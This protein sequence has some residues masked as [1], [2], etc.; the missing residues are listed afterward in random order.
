MWRYGAWVAVLLLSL[1]LVFFGGGWLGIYRSSLRLVSV[2]LAAGVLGAWALVAWRR[3]AWR[4]RSRLMPAIAGILGAFA[5]ST[6]VSRHPRQ[7]VEYLGYAVLLAALYLL[8]VRVLADQ[9][10]R[11]RVEI[12]SVGLA[13]VL[14]GAFAVANAARWVDWW[15]VVGRVTV[16][17]LRPDSEGLVYGNPS[18]AMTIV[19]LFA[20][21]ALPVLIGGPRGPRLIAALIGVLTVF[22]IVVSGSRA[23]WFAVGIA[24]VAVG[25]SF[26]AA[27]PRR[28]RLVAWVTGLA[29]NLRTRIA[30]AI[31]GVAVIGTLVLLTPLLVQR[32]TI[33]G[34]GMRLAYVESAQRMFA[35]S[36][37]VGVGPGTWV[38]ERARYTVSPEVDLY[39][40]HAHNIYAQAAAEFGVL[41]LLAG[42]VLLLGLI[43][44]I[45]DAIGDVDP[46]RRRWGW[47]TA[48]AMTYFAAHQLLDVYANMTAV[49][50]AAA[51]P[52]AWL[53][54]TTSRPMAT[55]S[56]RRA[57]PRGRLAAVAGIG[58]MVVS[59]LGLAASEIPASLL[60][61]AVDQAN[62]GAWP[63]ADADARAA[64]ALDPG[65]A[66]YQF[67]MGLTAAHLGDHA[68]AATEFHRVAEATDLP[69]AWVDLAAEEL[70]LGNEAAA[71]DAV[72]RAARLGLQRPGVAMAIG[73]LAMRL[74]ETALSESAFVEALH[75]VPSLAGDP[76]WQADPVRSALYPRL[77]DAAIQATA[78]GDRWQ[79]ALMAGDPDRASS[80][81]SPAETVDG[82]PM[83]VIAAWSGDEPA[84]D[85]I[86]ELCRAN[87]LDLTAVTWAARLEGRRGNI[88]AA[89]RYREWAYTVSSA[90]GVAGSE[91][92]VADRE[93][94]GRSVR[95]DVAE[96]WG[97]YTFRRAT[98]WNP[99]VPS[100]VQLTLE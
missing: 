71:V 99:W 83:L 60:E 13:V 80:L 24:V 59:S 76:W 85:R 4:P 65:W 64:V 46:Q 8:L 44:L 40:P 56:A 42:L 73:D 34:A 17:P 9:F 26:V 39:V 62:N 67:T 25:A 11:R 72:H 91:M 78:P 93:L 14:G 94:L 31:A 81:L 6:L 87:P 49:L 66:P 19:L 74:G 37:L 70:L 41:G 12:L 77:V 45:R 38:I 7:S 10:L 52:V 15:G 51:I 96:Q 92:R 61:R 48:F 100:M 69:E 32:L 89:N 88:D 23:G 5:I 90:G 21:C 79:L 86:I 68:R 20:C 58:L 3:P 28:R 22:A 57:G 29:G 33:S 35:E 47:A 1:Y 63:E 2:L 18:A 97:I 50:F 84:I 98:P 30:L 55:I 75:L 36:P 27:A 54:A 43:G 95:G 16:P 53:D 82:I